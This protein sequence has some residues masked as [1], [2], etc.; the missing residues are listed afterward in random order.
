MACSPRDDESATA[1]AGWILRFDHRDR[2]G[3]AAMFTRIKTDVGAVDI[4]T[5]SFIYSVRHATVTE[6][7]AAHDSPE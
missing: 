5:V 7:T 2:Y 6:I 3:Y 4:V 1:P